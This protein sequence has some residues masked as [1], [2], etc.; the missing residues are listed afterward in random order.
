MTKVDAPKIKPLPMARVNTRIRRNQ[1]KYIKAQAK[2][3]NLTEGEVYRAI[4]DKD[5]KSKKK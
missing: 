2:I 3:Q 5:M 4:I 1:Q